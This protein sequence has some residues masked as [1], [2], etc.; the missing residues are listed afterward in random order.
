MNALL[1]EDVL[2]IIWK[3][4]YD[5]AVLTPL[6]SFID[7]TTEIPYIYKKPTAL[8]SN[9]FPLFISSIYTDEDDRRII[10]ESTERHFL[11]KR[12]N[13]ALTFSQ[14]ILHLKQHPTGLF[15]TGNKIEWVD[16]SDD[17]L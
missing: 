15:E 5:L 2:I 9:D 6:M 4:V 3:R 10:F 7:M 14:A 16:Y 17:E 8:L 12:Y 11:L 13:H 1:S